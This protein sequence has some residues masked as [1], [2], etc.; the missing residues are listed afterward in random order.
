V[1]AARAWGL[2]P[3]EAQLRY[4][5]SE[6]RTYGAVVLAHRAYLVAAP[7]AVAGIVLA[8]RRRLVLWPLLVSAIAV[9][10]SAVFTYGN[11]RFRMAFEPSIVVLAAVAGVALRDRLRARTAPATPD[12]AAP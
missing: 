6:S 10:V 5:G 12:P 9:T 1:R 2:Y 11:Q 3:T 7:F 8:R 4:E